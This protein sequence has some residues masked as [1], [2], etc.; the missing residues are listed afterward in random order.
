MAVPSWLFVGNRIQCIDTNW[1]A[2]NFVN[3]VS[4]ELKKIYTIEEVF[5]QYMCVWLLELPPP[6]SFR[7]KRLYL[8]WHFRPLVTN[9]QENDI[10][11]FNKIL[12]ETKQ[13]KKEYA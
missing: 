9:T 6:K 8:H 4:P 11:L 3:E 1:L 12:D 5:P 7:V 13:P 10:S 2:P